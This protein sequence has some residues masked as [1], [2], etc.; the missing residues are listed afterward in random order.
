MGA[1]TENHLLAS[2]FLDL[3]RSGMQHHLWQYQD[4][5]TQTTL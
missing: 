5:S 2:T 3:L 4:V 1:T